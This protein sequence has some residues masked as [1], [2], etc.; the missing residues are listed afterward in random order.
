MN[1]ILSKS[2]LS[3]S[4]LSKSILSKSIKLYLIIIITIILLKPNFFYDDKHKKFKSFGMKKYDSLL[5]LPLFSIL[6]A[7][8]SYILFRIIDKINIIKLQYDNII[9]KN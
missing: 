8:S 1:N 4:I 3:K 2:I 5:P 6:L 7:I 9:N